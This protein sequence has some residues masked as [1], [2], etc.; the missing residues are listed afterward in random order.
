MDRF[1]V[2][3]DNNNERGNEM[4]ENTDST[5]DDVIAEALRKARQGAEDAGFSQGA[6]QEDQ[7]AQGAH[8]ERYSR[9]SD[10]STAAGSYRG[11]RT[12]RTP[13]EL[14]I[15]MSLA[16]TQVLI[17]YPPMDNRFIAYRTVDVMSGAI[18]RLIAMHCDPAWL[19]SMVS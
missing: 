7:G 16:G 18:D 10:V 4:T 14:G 6:T 5:V 15:S 8:T 2:M 13:E 3:A 1:N 11:P 19:R 12:R 9:R 17:N